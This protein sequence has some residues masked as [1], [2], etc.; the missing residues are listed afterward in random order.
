MENKLIDRIY[1]GDMT[2][3]S[4]YLYGS[5]IK[6]SGSS[7]H[8]ENPYFAAGKAI[9]TWRSKTNYQS[10][11]VSPSL[12]IL[13]PGASYRVEKDFSSVPEHTCYLQIQY[14]NRQE[15]VIGTE[16]LK[17]DDHNFT[18]PKDAYTYVIKLVGAGCQQV[19][20]HSLSLYGV[21]SNATIHLS[22]ESKHLYK[23][24]TLPPELELVRNVIQIVDD[25]G[26]Q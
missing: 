4:N 8:F 11:R 14:F 15:E 10:Q 6:Y 7:V 2:S 25:E 23:T 3:H 16:I 21:E 1:W 24:S 18:Y 19:S 13:V 9:K 5:T 20:F 22:V 17:K 12:P 26:V